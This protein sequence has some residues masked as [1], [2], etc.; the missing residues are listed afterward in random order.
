M[1]HIVLQHGEINLTASSSF[2]QSPAK[3]LYHNTYIE[4]KMGPKA[5]HQSNVDSIL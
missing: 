3:P 1:R 5:W 4:W 2:V